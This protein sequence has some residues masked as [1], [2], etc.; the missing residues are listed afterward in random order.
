MGNAAEMNFYLWLL[1][2]IFYLGV[3]L[4]PLGLFLLVTPG[5]VI[6]LANRVNR[7]ISTKPVFDRINE[8]IYQE[9]AFYRHHRL[10]GTVI[11]LL[12][13]ACLYILGIHLDKAQLMD[14]IHNMSRSEFVRWLMLDLY[15][16]LLAGLV[17]SLVLGFVIFERPSTL[18]SLADRANRWLD[19]ESHLQAFD[20]IHDIPIRVL[21]GRLRLFGVFVLAGA[22]YMMYATGTVIY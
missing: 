21:P 13:L 22:A 18:K 11:T 17:I 15:Y 7:W 9:K 20:S 12:S 4:I 8:P 3:L 14:A 6:H 16:I 19:S 2:S 1:T 5:K 10:F